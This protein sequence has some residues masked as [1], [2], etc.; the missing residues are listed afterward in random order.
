MPQRGRRFCA[1]AKSAGPAQR[2]SPKRRGE[3][4]LATALLSQSEVGLGSSKRAD[5][6]FGG[7]FTSARLSFGFPRGLQ[8]RE[9]LPKSL[10]ANHQC[11]N[12]IP[13]A[14]SLDPTE[15]CGVGPFATVGTE[16]ALEQ[17]QVRNSRA[18]LFRNRCSM[19]L[20]YYAK[21]VARLCRQNWLG[22][23]Q[24]HFLSF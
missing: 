17:F 4:L 11:A 21:S 22:F 3:L 18:I 15:R 1:G 8:D 13:R 2:M 10:Y 16:A 19:G 6:G 20:H 23:R 7:T 5:A 24:P 12:I 9:S 14:L